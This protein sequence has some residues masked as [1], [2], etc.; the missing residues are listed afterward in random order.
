MAKTPRPLRIA[1]NSDEGEPV[2]RRALFKRLYSAAVVGLFFGTPP[3]VSLTSCGFDE[4]YSY[5]TDHTYT[6]YANYSNSY[7]NAYSDFYYDYYDTYYDLYYNF[8]A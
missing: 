2:S 6:N 5:Y 1:T 4:D 8:A 7:S 3:A